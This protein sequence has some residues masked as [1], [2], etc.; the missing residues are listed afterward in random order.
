MPTATPQ[1]R[2]LIVERQQKVLSKVRLGMT[3]Q[4]IASELGISPATVCRD[5]QA[6]LRDVIT[7]A[8]DEVMKLHQLRAEWIYLKAAQIADTTG[9]EDRCL[10]ALDRCSVALERLAKLQGVDAA[11]KV[12][13]THLTLDE[14]DR[15]IAEAEAEL[16]RSD[17]EA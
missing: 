6:A 8:S 16:A 12:D 4:D 5:F 17:A 3:Y 9:N 13:I 1:E 7:P 2:V 10:R 11:L 15:L 14:V